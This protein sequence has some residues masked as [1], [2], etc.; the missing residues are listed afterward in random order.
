MAHIMH[1]KQQNYKQV[2]LLMQHITVMFL[3]S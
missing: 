3:C 1:L 2:I